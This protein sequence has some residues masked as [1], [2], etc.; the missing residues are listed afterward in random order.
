LAHFETTSCD[1][2][3][4]GFY[5]ILLQ[6]EAMK[7]YTRFKYSIFLRFFSNKRKK[8]LD[9]NEET[10]MSTTKTGT[11]TKKAALRKM[12]TATA[13]PSYTKSTITSQAKATNK[14]NHVRGTATT[15]TTTTKLKSTGKTATT[16]NVTAA[17]SPSAVSL[18]MTR[19]PSTTR[20]LGP[21][22]PPTAPLADCVRIYV[23]SRRI[24]LE[25]I[26]QYLLSKD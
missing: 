23:S 7:N 8:V 20:A 2:E 19:K 9:R 16:T 13:P 4:F 17:A 10:T 26:I 15:T 11:M 25:C 12:S 21:S 6:L 22:N 14:V 18:A 1:I 5:F 3:V 24:K